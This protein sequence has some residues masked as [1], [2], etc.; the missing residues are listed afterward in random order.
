M[1]TIGKL[2]GS[3]NGRGIKIVATATLGTTI[4]TAAA[5]TTT[6]DKM[7]VYLYN[8]HTAN[9]EVT[10]EI[11]GATDPD[12]H[13]VLTVPYDSGKYVALDGDI[14]QNSLVLTAFASVA[15]VVTARGYALTST[16]DETT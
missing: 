14:L 12:D 7:Y 11:G 16:A 3:T 6:W 15:N 10:L 4:H 9:V 1:S 5:G 8:S 13:V 2:S